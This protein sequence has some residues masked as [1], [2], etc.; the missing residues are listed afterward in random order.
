VLEF[1]PDHDALMHRFDH[2]GRQRLEYIRQRGSYDDLPLD[3]IFATFLKVYPGW[4]RDASGQIHRTNSRDRGARRSL[5]RRLNTPA[6]GRP[7]RQLGSR[8][9]MT[10]WHC[11]AHPAGTS[12]RRTR[13]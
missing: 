7:A 12:R 4:E 13:C 3:E 6:A 11:A 1:D 2:H 5:S 10:P 9:G 8:H